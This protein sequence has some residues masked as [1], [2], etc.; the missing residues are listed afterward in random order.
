M[1]LELNVRG[2]RARWQTTTASFG[3]TLSEVW[4]WPGAGVGVLAITLFVLWGALSAAFNPAPPSDSLEQVLLSQELR[5]EYGKHPPLPTWILHGVSRLV[6]PSIGATF[7]LGALCSVLTLLLLYA[8]A[9]PLV[10]APRAALAT[11]LASTIEFLNA[12]TAYFNH[13]TV[14][15]PLAMLAI[16]LFHRAVTRARLIDWALLGLGAALMMLAKYSALILFASFFL[17]LLW[18]G[19][20][21]EAS[22]W[23]GLAMA[24]FVCSSVL[25]P[26]LVAAF[27]DTWAP[28]RYAMDAVFPAQV[29]RLDRLRSVWSFASSQVAKVAPALLIFALLRWRGPKAAPVR[30]DPVPLGPF[31]GIVGF[32]PLVLTIVVALLAGARLL[33]GWGTTFHLLLTLWLVTTQPFAID[34]TPRVLRRAVLACIATQVVL[35]SV[36]IAFGGRLPNLNR[37][38]PQQLAEIPPQLAGVILQTWARHSAAPLRFVVSDARTGASLVA[39]FLGRPHVVDGNRPELAK[40]FPPRL[41]AACG[42]IVVSARPP[43]LPAD[44]SPR[45][46]LDALFDTV[47]SRTEVELTLRDGTRR[48]YVI[49]VR[50]PSPGDLCA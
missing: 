11:L 23:R 49:G 26:Q 14:Q 18:V 21:R 27:G 1:R 3:R 25:S 28:N 45:E 12:G 36:M 31:L 17:Y 33:V 19:R 15:L 2:A 30:N 42:A 50:T 9:R 8:W 16:V 6:G 37:A 34:A 41:Q 4:H 44:S 32:G 24:A 13:N 46:P 10:G 7:V 20:L 5:L 39:T 35:W 48:R 22:T 47:G 43:A 40:N 29:D 38:A